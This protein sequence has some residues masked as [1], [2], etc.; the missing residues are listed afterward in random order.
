MKHG[1]NLKLGAMY[2]LKTSRPVEVYFNFL[3]LQSVIK[4]TF[5]S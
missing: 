3:S 1:G 2:E 5:P 4:I